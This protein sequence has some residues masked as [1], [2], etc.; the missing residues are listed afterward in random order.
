MICGGFGENGW[1]FVGTCF[2]NFSWLSPWCPMRNYTAVASRN[3]RDIL[4]G[5]SLWREIRQWVRVAYSAVSI[6]VLS[7]VTCLNVSRSVIASKKIPRL[8][9]LILPS[10]SNI[11]FYGTRTWGKSV[12]VGQYARVTL[13][14]VACRAESPGR[15]LSFFFC[16]ASPSLVL[17]NCHTCDTAFVSAPC[18]NLASLREHVRMHFHSRISLSMIHT[19]ESWV[20]LNL[21]SGK[22]VLYDMSKIYWYTCIRIMLHTVILCCRWIHNQAAVF[23]DVPT[24]MSLC[25]CACVSRIDKCG[26]IC[27]KLSSWVMP[28]GRSDSTSSVVSVIMV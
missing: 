6:V 25:A 12:F 23:S 8:V 24:L 2:D 17:S 3:S 10:F 26:G 14:R 1:R 22:Y 20:N 27:E 21:L 7:I 19:D 16:S 5:V 9:R 15:R 18:D 4:G 28:I 13:L 11:I